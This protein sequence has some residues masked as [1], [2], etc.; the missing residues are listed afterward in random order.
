MGF[1]NQYILP[2]LVHSVCRHK[3]FSDQRRKIVPLARGRVLEV[4]IGSGLNLPF[5]DPDKVSHVWGLDPSESMQDMAEKRAQSSE[6]SFAFLNAPGKAIPLEKNDADTILIT[7]TLC[8]IAEVEKSFDEMRRVLKQGGK[9]LF[10][11]HGRS[12]DPRIRSCQN[13]LNPFWR[14]VSGGCNLNRNIPGIIEGSG[15]KI[16]HIES[17]YIPGFK[18]AGFN[19]WG[20]A[21][22][23]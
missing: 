21:L 20:A 7:Y 12:P 15:F 18:I 1:Y 5:Y 13:R 19:Y 3:Q 10:C 17:M 6:F 11:E 16:D 22:Q 9:L 8:T 2:R 14:F 4:G 23:R